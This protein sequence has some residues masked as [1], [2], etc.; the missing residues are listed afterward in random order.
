MKGHYLSVFHLC[1]WHSN[2]NHDRLYVL[3]LFI[4]AVYLMSNYNLSQHKVVITANL[5]WHVRDKWS[6]CGTAP[7]V[8]SI[9][10]SL[11]RKVMYLIVAFRKKSISSLMSSVYCTPINL[12]K[13]QFIPQKETLLH[14]KM[15]HLSLK[16]SNQCWQ[17]LA[18]YSSVS[19]CL[20]KIP[21][22]AFVISSE[23]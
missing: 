20:L 11:K 14:W 22:N 2:R 13:Q 17:T 1:V 10:C 19:E 16:C 8:V 18:W 5:I 3:C 21:N 15:L 12:G 4:S 6:L 23:I 7:L 9:L